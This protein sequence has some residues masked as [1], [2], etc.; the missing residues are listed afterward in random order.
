[1]AKSSSG[2][3]VELSARNIYLKGVKAMERMLNLDCNFVFEVE[4][5]EGDSEDMGPVVGGG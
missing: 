5:E 1:M 4:T 2:E 3:Q